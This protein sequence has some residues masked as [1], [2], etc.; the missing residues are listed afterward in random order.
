LTAREALT[1]SRDIQ[2]GVLLAFTLQHFAAIAGLRLTDGATE[3]RDDRLRSARLLGYADARLAALEAA[4]E[5]TERQE[6]DK[7]VHALREALGEDELAKLMAEGSTWT[8][9]HAVAEALLV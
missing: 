7:L 5:Y 3:T 4:R 1:L 6:Y 8:E 2:A 9:D